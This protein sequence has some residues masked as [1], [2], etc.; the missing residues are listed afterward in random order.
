MFSIDLSFLNTILVFRSIPAAQAPEEPEV[1]KSHFDQVQEIY[2][3]IDA[4]YYETWLN[5]ECRKVKIPQWKFCS[6]C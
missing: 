3:K 2:A 4:I 1:P 6:R 5:S